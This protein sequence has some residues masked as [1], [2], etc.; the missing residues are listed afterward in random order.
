[1]KKLTK[2]TA[3]G[4]LKILSLTLVGLMSQSLAVNDSI[5]LHW[6]KLVLERDPLAVASVGPPGPLAPFRTGSDPRNIWYFGLWI[7]LGVVGSS[8]DSGLLGPFSWSN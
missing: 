6:D 5:D 3:K 2:I 7:A 8:S 4:L 1:M